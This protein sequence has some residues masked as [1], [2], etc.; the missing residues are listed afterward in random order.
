MLVTGNMLRGDLPVSGV[1]SLVMLELAVLPRVRA[2]RAKH[3]A[4]QRRGI[5]LQ[6]CGS[7]FLCAA[8]HLRL[9]LVAHLFGATGSELGFAGGAPAWLQHRLPIHVRYLFRGHCHVRY[10]C[11]RR[12]V[13]A[14]LAGAAMHETVIVTRRMILWLC[15]RADRLLRRCRPHER[16]VLATK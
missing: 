2:L 14:L 3:C 16:A 5:R 7:A 15:T 9:R 6:C 1:M 13:T 10:S 11:L 4:V 12:R 8:L